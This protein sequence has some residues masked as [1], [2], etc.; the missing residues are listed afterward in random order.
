MVEVARAVATLFA[1]SLIDDAS[2]VEALSPDR[3]RRKSG[4]AHASS[5]DLSELA[6]IL[7][8]RFASEQLSQ[9]VSSRLNR[10][11]EATTT[12]QAPAGAAHD[13]V[14]QAAKDEWLLELVARAREA[15]P[16]DLRLVDL[17]SRVGLYTPEK[18]AIE[19]GQWVN[20][21]GGSSSRSSRHRC[22]ADRARQA[23]KRDRLS[24]WR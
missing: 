16:G 6:T 17:A 14:A 24:H 22:A 1:D 5:E 19:S 15:L 18:D 2:R 21:A 12:W 13:L 3:G 10:S 20:M 11:L 9:F 4:A 23:R 8:D 7:S